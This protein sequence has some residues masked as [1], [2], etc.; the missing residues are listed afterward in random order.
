ML[1]LR[2]LLVRPLST[3]YTQT[4]GDNDEFSDPALLDNLTGGHPTASIIREWLTLLAVCHT[5]VPERDEVDKDKIVYQ[6]SSPDENALVVAVKKLGFSFN[7][8][9]PQM[10]FINALGAQFRHQFLTCFLRVSLPFATLRAPCDG[11]Y[12]VPVLIGC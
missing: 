5:V 6:A 9:T 1:S 7:A 3:P 4:E 12:L 10:V 8:R 2:L 11:T